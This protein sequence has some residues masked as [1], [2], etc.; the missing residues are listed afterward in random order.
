M[1]LNKNKLFNPIIDIDMKLIGGKSNGIANLT[2]T[3]YSWS[4]KILDAMNQNF[5]QPNEISLSSDSNE[6]KKLSKEEQEAFDKIISFLIFIDS[7]I[8]NALPFLATY[9]T[10]PEVQIL[11][12]VHAFQ[13]SI[14]SQSYAYILESVVSAQK[15]QKIY[16]LACT[17]VQMIKRNEYIAKFHQNFIDNPTDSNFLKVVIAQF[18]LESIYFYSGFAFFYNLARNGKLTGVSQEIVYINRDENVHMAL[19]AN[20]YKELKKENPELFTETIYS[21]IYTM[22]ETAV[23]HEIEWAHY[24]YGDSIQG[25]TKASIAEYIKFTAN[26]RLKSLGLKILYPEITKNPLPFISSMSDSNGTK[27][28]FFE[29]KVT[30]YAKG[31]EKLALDD[32]DDIEL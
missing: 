27:T 13:E 10:L 32:I 23:N 29:G 21:E 20:I 9:I 16:D 14:H 19:F 28:D 25:L 8:T 7:M 15:R 1:K 26:I 18:I 11:L 24:V 2:K 22:M 5:W 4:K 6:Y 12:T 30:N 31:S 3:K 17:D